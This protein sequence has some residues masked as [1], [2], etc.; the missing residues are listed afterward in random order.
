VAQKLD[1]EL[2]KIIHETNRLKIIAFLASV[3]K[4][5]F[6]LL[7]EEL[8]LTDGNLSTHL[9]VLEEADYIATEKEFVE[10]KP[11]SWY[12]ITPA[13]MTA[14]QA[15]VNTMQNILNRHKQ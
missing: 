9:R 7:R 6:V 11:R 3:E 14:F 1:R 15:Y 4:A 2:N 5:E 13:G 8:D 10:R 12:K